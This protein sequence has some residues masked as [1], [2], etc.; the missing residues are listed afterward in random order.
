MMPCA[1]NASLQHK[2]TGTL[3]PAHEKRAIFAFKGALADGRKTAAQ[4]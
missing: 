3:S 2:A 1:K 4:R